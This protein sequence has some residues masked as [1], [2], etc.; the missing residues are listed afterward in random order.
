LERRKL[1]EWLSFT[2]SEPHKGFS[3]L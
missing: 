2:R 3:P 1:Q